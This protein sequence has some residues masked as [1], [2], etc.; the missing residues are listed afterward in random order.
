M[1]ELP[2]VESVRR[3]LEP[4]LLG[5]RV[6]AATLRRPDILSTPPGEPRASTNRRLLVGG[7]ITTLCRQ[8]KQ[9]AMLTHDGR[10]CIV[11]LGM[12]GSLRWSSE[13]PAGDPSHHVHC[14]WTLGRGRGCLW[15]A[16]PRRFG[17][18]TSLRETSLPTHW[19]ALGPD[20]LSISG[21]H[22]RH[23]LELSRRAVK[24]SLLDQRTLAGVGNIY[25]DEALF[26]AKLSPHAP[27]CSLPPAAWENLA[28]AIRSILTQAVAAGGSTLRDYRDGEGNA[29]RYQARHNVYGRAGLPCPACG[30]PLSSGLLAQRTTVW[31]SACQG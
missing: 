13:P 22:L 17:G 2:E 12:T 20:A 31:C 18:L 7:R 24:A 3:T 26:V 21:A 10:A 30:S 5:A 11:Q 29:G 16:D 6:T 19:A 9:L 4:R 15:F 14:I 8:G 1:P 25:A 23:T 28:Q 27:C